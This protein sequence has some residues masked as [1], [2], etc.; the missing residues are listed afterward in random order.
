MCARKENQKL[1]GKVTGTAKSL[2]EIKR[3]N[4]DLVRTHELDRRAIEELSA[5]ISVS[6]EWAKYA[7]LMT[8]YNT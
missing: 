1:K 8:I 5:T 7:P 2:N 6:E 3:L 4:Y